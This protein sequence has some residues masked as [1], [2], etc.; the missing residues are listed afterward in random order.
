M[1]N[2]QQNLSELTS[3]ELVTVYGGGN[4]GGDQP[5]WPDEKIASLARG[6]SLASREL[7]NTYG[8]GNLSGE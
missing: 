3:A 7:S 6:V 1:K 2:D 8:I 5:Q 4:G